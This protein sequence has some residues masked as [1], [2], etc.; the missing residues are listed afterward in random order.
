MNDDIEKTTHAALAKH[1]RLAHDQIADA[2]AELVACP[3]HKDAITKA[4]DAAETHLNRAGL[5]WRA[6][7][8]THLP[9]P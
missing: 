3:Q 4:L 2:R 7:V 1:L 5:V 9:S 8:I 6:Y